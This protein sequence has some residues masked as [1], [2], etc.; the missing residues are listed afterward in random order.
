[1]KKLLQIVLGVALCIGITAGIIY[2]PL[3]IF[4]EHEDQPHVY[5]ITWHSAVV[6]LLLL[7]LTQWC[8]HLIFSW[9]ESRQKHESHKPDS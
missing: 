5:S 2:L 7:L 3:P 4:W 8:S 1:M 9:L 6:F